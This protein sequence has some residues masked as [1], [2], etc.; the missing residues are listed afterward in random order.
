MLFV[1]MFKNSVFVLKD[2]LFNIQKCNLLICLFVCLFAFLLKENTAVI[3][4][5][6]KGISYNIC[7]IKFI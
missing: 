4:L 2:C 6:C 1:P 7:N 3:V 5:Y